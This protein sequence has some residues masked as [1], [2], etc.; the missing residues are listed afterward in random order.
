MKRLACILFLTLLAV[1]LSLVAQD[2][3][4]DRANELSERQRRAEIKM[5][6]LE[7]R[8][9]IIAQKLEAKEPERAQRLKE[10][11]NQAKDR[12][13]KRN[14][15]DVTKLL[16]QQKYDEAE[17]V[18]DAVILNLEELVRL[19]L[20]DNEETLSR[21][22]E[23]DQ[24]KKWRD[25]ISRLQRE[26]K[27]QTRETEKI[28]NKEDTLANLQ[29][30]IESVQQLIQQQQQVI[31]ETEAN[32]LRGLQ[33]LDRVADRQFEVRQNTQKL[34][35]EIAGQPLDDE[36][37]DSGASQPGESKSG[38]SK[39]GESKSGESKSGES[40]SSDSAATP[41]QPGEQPLQNATQN[42]QQ[43]EEQLT[44]GR[45]PAAKR[46]EEKALADLQQA[47]DELKK[48]QRR[49]ASLPPEAF[50]KMA[51]EQRSTERKTD[52]LAKDMKNSPQGQQSGQPGESG[53]SSQSQSP[54]QQPGQ[55]SVQR[56]QQ[57]MQNASGDL[58]QQEAQ[59]AA[60]QQKKAEEELAKALRE[61]E[62]RLDQLREETREEKLA[63]LESRFREMLMRQQM[64]TLV[65]ME[66]DDKKRHLGKLGRR[67]LLAMLRLSSEE[68][69]ISE[70]G[71]Q[72][73][74]LLLEDGSS[75][76]FPEIVQQVREDLGRAGQLLEAEQ[77]GPL[78]QLV[79]REIEAS[80]EEMLEALK[81]SRQEAGGGGG[82]GGGGGNQPLLQK[83]A[84]LKM[85][86]AAQLRVNRLTRQ[87]DLIRP[88]GT[89][90]EALTRELD[91]IR[92]RQADIVEMMLG[93][94]EKQ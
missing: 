34:A 89:L 61:I 51:Q 53:Q 5:A 88:D 56:A 45:A 64:A 2:P 27:Q 79:Q 48:E 52:D 44:E 36:K 3:T 37:S 54:P 91:N 9:E 33:A 73:Y 80:I 38:E 25:A 19:L 17:E 60:R 50:Q 59:K 55:Q 84:E 13:I 35:E 40:K 1:P 39:S 4:D 11:L 6:E 70:L 94:L 77:T 10:A 22:E 8:F 92:V 24:L 29:Q 68:W 46:S 76:V 28:A 18:L 7:A 47:L 82:G 58:G 87:F 71:Q 75:I 72:A 66:L 90:G 83:S 23:I 42:Q 21:Q 32:R 69:E 16:N 57:A 86:R 93:I 62:E 78:T 26:Q 74:D 63:R 65:T 30:Q 14:M 20:D 15:S 12:L 67:D 31:S 41:S 81:K 43:A 49:I 85:L